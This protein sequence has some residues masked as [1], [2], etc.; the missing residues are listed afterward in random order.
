M[1]YK[2]IAC[3]YDNT[4]GTR[5]DVISEKNLGAVKKYL[6]EGGIFVVCSGRM[7]SSVS[8]ITAKNDLDCDIIAYQGAVISL[9]NGKTLFSGGIDTETSYKLLRIGESRN[10]HMNIFVDDV[11]YTD[12][13]NEYTAFY[14]KSSGTVCVKAK[15]KLS[16]FVKDN[17]LVCQKI[18]IMN[19]AD[20][21]KEK[22]DFYAKEFPYLE[23]NSGA[24]CLTEIV[25]LKMNKGNALK[26]IAEYYGIDISET[27][28][29]GDSSN[30]VSM[31]E[32][33]GLGIAVGDGDE[34][35]KSKADVVAPD[36]KEDAV[37]Y[38]IENYCKNG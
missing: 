26:R 29:I 15:G 36:F 24:T 13:L 34:E 33:A 4:L 25:D 1:K 27:V 16:D 32:V 12:R 2:L 8:K 21:T 20:E 7:L 6:K 10:E 35:L 5:P 23:V 18:C 9:K 37:A 17:N 30:D 31:I 22:I 19:P 38:V 11:H 28:A 14:E 3:D